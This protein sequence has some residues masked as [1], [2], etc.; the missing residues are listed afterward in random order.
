MQIH[1][2]LTR[3]PETPNK[4]R[5]MQER[6]GKMENQPR[7]SSKST[8]MSIDRTESKTANLTRVPH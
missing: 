2:W 6:Q 4:S 7:E 1:E 8:T 3:A 5:G